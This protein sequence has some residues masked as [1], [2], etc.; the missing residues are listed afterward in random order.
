VNI[1]ITL[2]TTAA[3]FT[4]SGTDA[5]GTISSYLW[6]QYEGP[7]TATLTNASTATVTASNLVLGKYG[8]RLRVKDNHN[9]SGYD[10][11]NVTVVSGAREAT[12]EPVT[13]AELESETKRCDDCSII[14]YN[15]N[16]KRFYSGLF[17]YEQY[18]T[19]T[20]SL[21][22]YCYTLMRNS[23]KVDSGKVLQR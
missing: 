14:I 8:F 6:S 2:P 20:K 17:D 7:S 3:T 11:M 5:D 12:P 4:G 16:G 1:T 21:Q 19:I 10:Y 13:L 15:M 18:K 23:K 22:L 9:T